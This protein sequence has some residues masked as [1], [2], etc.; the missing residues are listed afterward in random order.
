MTWLHATQRASVFHRRA[1]IEALC[2]T[3]GYAR[4]G[5]TIARSGTPL[6]YGIVLCQVS[7]WI[8]AGLCLLG[9]RLNLGTRFAI[10]AVTGS[11]SW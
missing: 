1:W 5:L 8:T 7:S 10:E 11:A 4:F 6:G 9:I 2:H 3:Y